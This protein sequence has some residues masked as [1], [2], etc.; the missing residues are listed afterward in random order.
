MDEWMSTREI[1]ASRNLKLRTV[2]SW[3]SKGWLPAEKVGK[4]WRV[5][6]ADW[7]AFLAN[8]L[9]PA[10]KF[11][12]RIAFATRPQIASFPTSVGTG[13]GMLAFP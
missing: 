10:K 6:R 12:G 1:A 11:E 8:G 5:K 2:I 7:E 13:T 3:C 4:N 9:Q